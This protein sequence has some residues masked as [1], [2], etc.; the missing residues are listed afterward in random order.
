MSKRKREREN[1]IIENR[2]CNLAQNRLN[3][4]EESKKEKRELKMREREK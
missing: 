2:K 3:K 4:K 1:P